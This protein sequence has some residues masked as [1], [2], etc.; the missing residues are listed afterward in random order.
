[1]YKNGLIWMNAWL[2]ASLLVAGDAAIEKVSTFANDAKTSVVVYYSGAESLPFFALDSADGVFTLDLPGVYS[3]YDF[4]ELRF[5]QVT[6][7]QQVPLDPDISKGIS[8]RFLLKEHTEYQVFQD[9]AGELT[10]FFETRPQADAREEVAAAGEPEAREPADR[11]IPDLARMAS[12][13]VVE[14]EWGP[15]RFNR[16][17]VAAN[18]ESGRLFLNVDGLEDHRSF[19]L[20]DP[21]RFVL[22]LRETVLSL[23]SNEVA[24]DSSLIEKV[25]IR[26]FQ[27][28][29]EPITRLVLDLI[30][31]I[32]INVVPVEGGL[33]VAFARNAEQLA[34]LLAMPAERDA[35]ALPET[36]VAEST[37]AGPSETPPADSLPVAEEEMT[38]NQADDGVAGVEEITESPSLQAQEQPELNGEEGVLEEAEVL[39]DVTPPPFEGPAAQPEQADSDAAKD[40]PLQELPR[41]EE[42]T[43][44]PLDEVV[45]VAGSEPDHVVHTPTGTAAATDLAEES[46]GANEIASDA[47]HLDTIPMEASPEPG[48]GPATDIAGVETRV[49]EITYRDSKPVAIEVVADEAPRSDLAELSLDA[50]QSLT[51][52]QFVKNHDADKEMQDFLN[53][54]EDDSIYGMMK[55]QKSNRRDIGT[56]VVTNSEI[57]RG[58][59]LGEMR[60]AQVE[61]KTV[62]ED[63]ASLFRED[64]E[65]DFE[66]ETIG[67]GEAEYRGFE[68]SI[69]DVKDANVVDLLRFIADQVGINLYVDSSVGDIK[70]TYR[71]RNIPWDQALDIILTNANLNKE[72][73]NGV[74][75]VATTE[76]FRQEELARAQLRQQ[77]ELSVPVETVTFP[78]N[79]ADAADVVPIV[80]EYLSPRGTILMD[81]R[82]NTLIIE[83]IPNRMVAIR[84]LIKK[85]D[86]MISQ[87]TIEARVVETTKRFLREL[88]IQWGLN[89]D[90]SPE[91]GTDTGLEFPNRVGVEGP[92]I[93]LPRIPG[94][95][96]RGGYAV[97]FPIVAENPSGLGL[98]LGN[99]LDNFK[100]DIS[101][102]MLESEGFGQI[103]SSPKITT[104]NNKTATIQNGQR[105]P[106][107]TIQRGTITIRYID[108]VLELQVTPH[109]TSDETIIMDVV[110]NKSEPDF[111]RTVG[112]NPVINVRKAETKVLVK[113]G[114]TAVIGGIFTLNESRQDSG[115]PKLRNVPILKRIFSSEL[116]TYENQELLI[117]VT[118]RIV[119]Y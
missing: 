97:N 20:V 59:Q 33:M 42:E 32:N 106:I 67:G 65:A 104:Q 75:R 41:P 22:D 113:N 21:R 112:G 61:P 37:Q 109:I 8:V 47:A 40:L 100:L 48:A 92:I 80:S 85:L 6:A 78:L 50:D 7:V 96:P 28:H 63:F 69:I 30:E 93:G 56:M 114:G 49:E 5:E 116:N 76:K 11:V 2:C 60:A 13:Q 90:Y 72:F 15:N 110:V 3:K 111:T 34:G 73:R 23:E 52:P 53:E 18:P 105:I 19:R 36:V 82:T 68:I 79:Y 31:D 16:L 108:A 43:F 4:S 1:M 87:V 94:V 102:Q 44:L 66:P 74:L 10:L 55:G 107:Q 83:D 45:E 118:P 115:I 51:E 88:G 14:G 24:I 101:L 86:K 35:E 12:Y 103:I 9:R 89:A 64:D 84:A 39:A 98:T 25:R 81:E 38:A 27:S 70:A 77:R 46:P 17:I 57:E 26:Q 91:F 62:G 58:K 99:F 95:G 119:K 54:E 117:F 71:F 29:P